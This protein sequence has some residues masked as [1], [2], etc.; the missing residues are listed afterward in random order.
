[1]A[2]V[3][4]AQARISALVHPHFKVEA[5]CSTQLIQPYRAAQPACIRSFSS[6]CLPVPISLCSQFL[7]LFQNI[8]WGIGGWGRGCIY[9]SALEKDPMVRDI[10]NLSAIGPHTSHFQF[11]GLVAGITLTSRLSRPHIHIPVVSINKVQLPGALLPT[12]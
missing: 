7:Y 6:V 8:P 5:L 10:L 1:M 12:N 9:T 11:L 3:G 4:R 2:L